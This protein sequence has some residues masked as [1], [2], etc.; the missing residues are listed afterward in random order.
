M[1]KFLKQLVILSA[2]TLCITIAVSVDLTAQEKGLNAP[3]LQ[4]INSHQPITIIPDGVIY[5]VINHTSHLPFKESFDIR[6]NGRVTKEVLE[7]IAQE[8]KKSVRANPK[9]IYIVYYLQDMTVGA[10]GWASSH[11]NPE[12]KLTIYGSTVDEFAN[13][14]T[15]TGS[16]L[17]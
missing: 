7:L 5:S 16:M 10:G 14:N 13:G 2:C 9:R 17:D 11:F 3:Y 6:L 8:I 12:L 1:R 4:H 15:Y